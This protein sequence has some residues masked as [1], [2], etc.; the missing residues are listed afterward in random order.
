MKYIV[1]N[2]KL[3]LGY[4]TMTPQYLNE[5]AIN[6]GLEPNYIKNKNIPIRVSN[7]SDVSTHHDYVVGTEEVSEKVAMIYL[8]TCPNS[9][10]IYTMSDGSE[11]VVDI[12]EGTLIIHSGLKHKVI[13]ENNCT[14]YILGPFDIAK[15]PYQMVG[16][17]M[18]KKL[19]NLEKYDRGE[20]MIIDDNELM[21]IWEYDKLVNLD[22]VD[23]GG[24]HNHLKTILIIILLL[25][26]L[27]MILK[28]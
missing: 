4:V 3:K 18:G 7:Q 20:L 27:Y 10:I 14:R 1:N 25:I 26:I 19:T 24:W 12:I 6:V 17:P 22:C 15:H 5:L 2:P 21:R 23:D 16:A 28:K 11:E 8:N 13:G 9:K